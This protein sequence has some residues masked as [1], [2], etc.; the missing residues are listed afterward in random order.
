MSNLSGYDSESVGFDSVTR[1]RNIEC[2]SS[3]QTTEFSTGG[4]GSQTTPA[5]SFGCSVHPTDFDPAG[6]TPSYPPPGLNEFLRRVVPAMV[7]E[8]DK[9]YDDVAENSSDSD[10]EEV[11][12]VKL[13]QTIQVN[14]NLPTSG[15]GDHQPLIALSVSWSS[16]G[17]SLAVS[18]GRPQHENWCEHEGL[19]R[20]Y[21]VK[22]SEG[23]KLVHSMDITEKNCITVIKYH[24]TV[25][26]LLAYG[27]TSGEVVICNLRNVTSGVFDQGTQ[28]ASPSG[29]HTANRVSAMLWADAPL[30][31]MFLTMYILAT[32]KR[33]GAA[34]QVLI[35]SGTDGSVNVWQVNANQ[36]VFQN[37]ISYKIDGSKSGPVP[38]ISCFDFIKS[39]PLRPPEEKTPEDIFLIGSVSGRLYLCNCKNYKSTV[40]SLMVD[41]VY[42]ALEGHSTCVL[43]VAFS[44]QRPNI[45]ASISMDSELRVY[46][47]GQTAPLKVILTR[48]YSTI[49]LSENRHILNI[50]GRCLF[51]HSLILIP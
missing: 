21:T 41:P 7:E 38:D 8:L 5:K 39:Y 12:G 43:D 27:T 40:D 18:L 42:E 49:Y 47:I 33:R 4:T 45:F 37:V 9:N 13:F 32:G 29:F 51:L 2:N 15:S 35:T 26:A 50:V 20:I 24:P 10:E 19:I 30:A 1:K 48:G 17:N 14:D 34:D 23:D 22:R 16:A 28:L 46:D 6:K 25:A 44:F 3:T 11:L 36:Q 31:N